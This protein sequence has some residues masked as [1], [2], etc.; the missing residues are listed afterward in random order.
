MNKRCYIVREDKILL[1]SADHTFPEEFIIQP[2]NITFQIGMGNFDD[3]LCTAIVP[4]ENWQQPVD[5]ELFPIKQLVRNAESAELKLAGLAGFFCSWILNTKFCGRCGA[6]NQMHPNERAR[7]CPSCGLVSYP[8]ISPAII[9]AVIK[10]DKILLAHNR[11]FADGVF[12]T[13]AGFLEPGE[14]FEECVQREVLEETGIKVKNI[15]YFGNQSWLFPDSHMIGFTA[16]YESGEIHEDGDEIEHAEWFAVDNLP[17]IPA[18][19]SISRELIDW[20]VEKEIE[21]R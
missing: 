11:K 16:E 21:K 18:K 15:R 17:K 8:S 3:H 9:V 6:E 2:E 13:I 5:F 7:I 19:G 20:F 14:T 12:S 4:A 1:K 10:N